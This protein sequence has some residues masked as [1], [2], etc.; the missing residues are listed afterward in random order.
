MKII[1]TGA[2]GFAGSEILSHL[3][4]HPGVTQVSCLTRR[5]LD[6]SS[7]KVTTI[8]HENFEVYD[9][10]LIERLSDHTSCIW[11]LGGKQSD[12]G[13]PD[14]FAR[15]THSFTIALAEAVAS[16]ARNRFTFCYLSGMGADP[17][18]TARLPWEKLTRYLKGRTERDLARLQQMYPTFSA[19]SFRPG[20]ILPSPGSAVLRMLLAPI[21]VGVDELADAM[22]AGATDPGMFRRWPTITNANIKR[23]ARGVAC[24]PHD[25]RA[26]AT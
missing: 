21:V 18:E 22:I 2:T 5:P 9:T 24:G 13:S 14:Q 1:L 20:G 11:A 16:T 15:I 8:I 10:S 25:T 3:I 7:P 12:L 6:A 23:L 4:A 26:L 17:T 19:R